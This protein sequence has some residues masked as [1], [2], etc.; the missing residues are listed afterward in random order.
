MKQIAWLG[1]GLIGLPMASRLAAAGWKVSGFDVNPE[2]MKMAS[3]RGISSAASAAS[4]LEGAELVFTSMPNEKAFVD[5]LSGLRTKAI[6]IATSTVGPQASA[7]VA[8]AMKTQY[9]RAPI[10]GSVG[11]AESGQLTTF[12]SGPAVCIRYSDRS[13]QGLYTCAVL[14]TRRRR[15][16]PREAMPQNVRARPSAMLNGGLKTERSGPRCGLH[17]SMRLVAAIALLMLFGEVHAA[18][19]LHAQYDPQHDAIVAEIAYRGISAKHE[20]SVQW[21]D[22]DRTSSDVAEVAARL[23][24]RQ[25]AEPADRDYRVTQRFDIS[26]LDSC[27]PAQITLRLGRGSLATVD[28]PP[29]REI[30]VHA[31]AVRNR[32]FTNRVVLLRFG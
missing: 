12:V 22:C 16:V 17:D 6:V 10:S 14:G 27:R 2:R 18:A 11:H 13:V 1:L 30:A 24:D 9:L 4:A 5:V 29:A 32:V 15:G 8:A 19:I 3:Q 26:P 20:F 21:S 25:G 23:I 31:P 28:V 7:K